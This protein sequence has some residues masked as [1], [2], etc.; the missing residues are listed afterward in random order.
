MGLEAIFFYL[1]SAAAV[2]SAIFVIIAF[3]LYWMVITS[4]K[5][6]KEIFQRVP[7]FFPQ[8]PV[9]EHYI[10]VVQDGLFGYF[11]NSLIVSVAAT[12]VSV[13]SSRFGSVRQFRTV[14]PPA[15]QCFAMSMR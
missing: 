15:I 1:F 5:P 4:F 3:P 12:A 7:T 2:V 10:S 13:S 11:K 9:V 8:K 6:Y 14:L